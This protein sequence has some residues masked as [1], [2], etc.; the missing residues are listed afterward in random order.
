[1][2][3][4]VLADRPL[5]TSSKEPQESIIK[6]KTKRRMDSW[7]WRSN[8]ITGRGSNLKLINQLPEPPAIHKISNTFSAIRFFIISVYKLLFSV[9]FS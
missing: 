8:S 4:Q 1:M 3:A 6:R 7:K 5:M 9:I 2:G